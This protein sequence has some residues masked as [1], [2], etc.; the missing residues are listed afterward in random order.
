MALRK[1]SEVP[2]VP[3]ALPCPVPGPWL[4]LLAEVGVVG[5]AACGQGPGGTSRPPSPPHSQHHKAAPPVGA[6]G[7]ATR[8]GGG[9]A[10]LA[11]PAR[12]EKSLP[13]RAPGPRTPCG[14]SR[15]EEPIAVGRPLPLARRA[16]HPLQ[17]P[18]TRLPLASGR[19]PLL[20]LPRTPGASRGSTRG[21]RDRGSLQPCPLGP[22]TF[23]SGRVA[24]SSPGPGHSAR[25]GTGGGGAWW[26]LGRVQASAS[27]TPRHVTPGRFS[28]PSVDSRSVTR[29][30]EGPA[31]GVRPARPPGSAVTP[32]DV[33]LLISP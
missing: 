25:A 1:D 5:V 26:R 33:S 22:G 27:P 3:P 19:P 23:P 6:R 4:K 11:S 2:P 12:G 18:G 15:R 31:R 8:R 7:V 14:P 21:A 20:G 13:G 28:G 17:V 24:P 9:P 10:R 16:A 32:A 30:A 29:G